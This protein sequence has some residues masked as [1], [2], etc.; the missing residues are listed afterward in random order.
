[1]SNILQEWHGTIDEIDDGYAFVSLVDITAGNED[2]WEVGE[3]PIGKFN[4]VLKKGQVFR[5][6]ITNDETSEIT[7]IE[8][9]IFTSN[10]HRVAQKK[11]NNLCNALNGINTEKD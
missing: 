7:Q 8:L 4:W 3:I 2:A 10:D 9:G 5:W 6:I 11:A 1:M